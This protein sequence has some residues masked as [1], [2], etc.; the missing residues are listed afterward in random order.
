[1]S[2]FD[3]LLNVDGQ[4]LGMSFIRQR[5]EEDGNLQALLRRLS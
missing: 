3:L 2:Y 4:V 5:G 1:M